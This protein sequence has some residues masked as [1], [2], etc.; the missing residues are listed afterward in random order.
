MVHG[1]L[2]SPMLQNLTVNAV[3]L[4][5]Y[6]YSSNEARIGRSSPP[7]DLYA[8]VMGCCQETVLI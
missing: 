8:A 2:P 5:M 1:S 4:Q 3:I 7:P 6:N